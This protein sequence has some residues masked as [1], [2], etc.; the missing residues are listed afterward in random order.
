MDPKF[1][2]VTQ[3]IPFQTCFDVRSPLTAV[4]NV[5]SDD[6]DACRGLSQE[7]IVQ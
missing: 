6:S 1:S 4:I 2:A 3:E 5:T 7:K